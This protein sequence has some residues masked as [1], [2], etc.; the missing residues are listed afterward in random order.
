MREP[1]SI[2]CRVEIE[3]EPER[4]ERKRERDGFIVNLLI[5]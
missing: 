2:V 5:V 1:Q 4:A 3:R